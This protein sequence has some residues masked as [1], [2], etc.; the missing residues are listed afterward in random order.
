MKFVTKHRTLGRRD[1]DFASA[2]GWGFDMPAGSRILQVWGETGKI[3]A[4]T[5]EPEKGIETGHPII[6]V[7]AG[8]VFEPLLGRKT[9]DYL[10]QADL[11][12]QN[13]KIQTH[14]FQDL[15][16]PEGLAGTTLVKPGG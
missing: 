5:L 16:W 8:V 4:F 12:I 15:P 14:L 7:R 3:K 10:G 1:E 13:Q 2:V 6:L 9:G 11:L